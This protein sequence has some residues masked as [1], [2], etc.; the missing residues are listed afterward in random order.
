MDIYISACQ[1]G[2]TLASLGLGWVG[3]SAFSKLIEPLLVF[4]G[5]TS[6]KLS[7]FIAFTTGFA[8]IS[9]LP[10]HR[11]AYAKIYGD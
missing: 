8:L 10:I 1:L 7:T 11:R 3:E 9:F 6:L 5:I 4:L 2:I